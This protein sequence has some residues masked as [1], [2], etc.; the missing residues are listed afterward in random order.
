M[1]VISNEKMNAMNKEVRKTDKA[2]LQSELSEIYPALPKDEL[3]G[4][5][6]SGLEKTGRYGIDEDLAIEYFIRLMIEVA[7]DFDEYPKAQEQLTRTDVNPN[8][9]VQL[10]RELLTPDEWR[11]AKSFGPRASIAK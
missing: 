6:E 1:L 8:L 7:R 11:E 9:T 10:A 5:I 4:F 3:D 2:Q